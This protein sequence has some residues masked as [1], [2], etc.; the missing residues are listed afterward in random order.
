MAW[1]KVDD[2][3]TFHPKVISAGNEA[4]GAW[5]RLGAYCG[6]HLTNGKLPAAIVLS[7]CGA[8]LAKHLV[9]CRF[10][11]QLPDGTYSMHDYLH[12]NPSAEQIRSERAATAERVSK[13]RNGSRNGVTN[14][15]SNPSP[16]PDP[17]PDPDPIPTQ[18]NPLPV[19][20][21]AGVFLSYP[22]KSNSNQERAAT[23]IAALSND[24]RQAFTKAVTAYARQVAVE[25]TPPRFVTTWAVFCEGKW[26]DYAP[27]GKT[28]GAAGKAYDVHELDADP[29]PPKDAA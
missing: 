11:D 22:R 10:L 9:A 28:N 21:L 14:G 13:W 19:G 4:V 25:K 20:W 23:A 27:V 1:F 15:V 17:D 6:A 5:V 3:F 7:I 29:P 16:D 8:E 2:R 26:R 12:Y 18:P 24:D